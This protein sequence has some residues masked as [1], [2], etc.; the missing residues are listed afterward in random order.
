MDEIAEIQLVAWMET[1]ACLLIP[2]RNP[3]WRLF[4]FQSEFFSVI[5]S[6]EA[7]FLNLGI[8]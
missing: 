2:Y 8:R 1:L 3:R 5:G 7:P 6:L 4:A